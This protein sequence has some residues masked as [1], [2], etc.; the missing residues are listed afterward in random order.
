VNVVAGRKTIGFDRRIRLDWLDATAEWA[1]QGLSLP[2]IRSRLDRLLEGQVAGVGHGSARDKTMTVLLHVWVDVLAALVPLRDGDT[3]PVHLVQPDA[4]NT[5]VALAVQYD[6]IV[7]LSVG[8][9]THFPSIP[10]KLHRTSR[11]LFVVAAG[12]DGRS[13][14]DRS[15]C[16]ARYGS[17][18][19]GQY[20]LIT[21]AAL[22]VDGTLAKFSNY[23]EDFVDIAAQGCHQPTLRYDGNLRSFETYNATGASLAAPL[24]WFTAGL[25]RVF[26]SDAPPRALKRRILTGSD[27]SDRLDDTEV[28]DRRVERGQN[29]VFVSGRRGSEGGRNRDR[30]ARTHC[31]S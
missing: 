27:I 21:V 4:F 28:A 12:N 30:S 25:L 17:S 9:T 29:P 7:N 11:V 18:A 3:C 14:S 13:L 15:I 8:R 24:V 20:N 2:E 10:E 1:A 22:D 16:P 26:W 5:S 19:A 23:G 6:G 31:Q